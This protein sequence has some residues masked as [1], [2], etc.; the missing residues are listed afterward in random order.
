MLTLNR[1]K[2]D[3]DKSLSEVQTKI[4]AEKKKFEVEEQKLANSEVQK[5]GI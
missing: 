4:E 1:E 5:D 2:F 3:L